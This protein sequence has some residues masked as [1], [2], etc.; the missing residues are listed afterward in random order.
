MSGEPMRG[1]ESWEASPEI[2]GMLLNVVNICVGRGV[3]VLVI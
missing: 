1:M 2:L 3:A